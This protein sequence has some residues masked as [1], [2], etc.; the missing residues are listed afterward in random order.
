MKKVVAIFLCVFVLCGSI[1][2]VASAARQNYY[3][4]LKVDYYH[5]GQTRDFTYK[6]IGFDFKKAYCN[7]IT[8]AVIDKELYVKQT[9]FYKKA[10]TLIGT[11]GSI[12]SSAGNATNSWW[13]NAIQNA[14]PGNKKAYWYFTA[15][16]NIKPG[17]AHEMIVIP[18]GCANIYSHN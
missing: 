1:T 11:Q 10:G 6:N 14:S 3:S 18:S 13:G 12:A 9:L 4:S 7:G 8:G 5:Q 16:N 17:G 2:F 15:R